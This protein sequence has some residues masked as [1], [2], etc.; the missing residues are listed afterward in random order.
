M[1]AVPAWLAALAL[2]CGGCASK[3][4]SGGDIDPQPAQAPRVVETQTGIASIHR[5]GYRTASGERFDPKSLTAAHR[6]WPF[7]TRV[8]VTHLKTGKS[9]IVR[10]NDRGP[11]VR[12]R[13]IDLTPAAATAIGLT[14]KAGLARVKLER[15]SSD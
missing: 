1:R 13:V 12:G 11:F 10:I 3:P 4:A 2:W 5:S 9:V 6:T 8:R 15:L 7:G 14:W